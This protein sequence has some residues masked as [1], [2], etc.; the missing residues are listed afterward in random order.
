AMLD[1]RAW[2]IGELARGTGVAPS[3]ASEHVTRLRDAGFV[4]SVSQG[5]H[6]YV[7]ITDP[8]VAELVERLAEH[9]QLQP[10]RGLRSSLR[11]KRLTFA[12]S[13]YDHVAGV[14]GVALHDGMLAEGLIDNSSGLVVTDTGW[15]AL[16]EF[17]VQR[18]AG[19]PSR[20][21]VLRECL[22]WTQR[23]EHFGGAL[24]ARLLHRALAAGW[25]R[26][27]RERELR[28]GQDAAEP[29]ALLGVDLPALLN[30]C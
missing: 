12:R 11:A 13:C 6:R 14:L 29:F 19:E 24:P 22:D 15:A 26:R 21:P 18:T 2:T 16:R 3:T 17:G 9:A 20:R 5:R 23:R 4:D 25:I 10:V 1:G 27:G 28:V 30:A 7:R 8:R